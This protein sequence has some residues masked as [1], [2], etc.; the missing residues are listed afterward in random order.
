MSIVIGTYARRVAAGC[1]D[2]P[3]IDIV[4][5]G[6][7]HVAELPALD[8]HGELLPP[9]PSRQTALGF[10]WRAQRLRARGG[11]ETFAICDAGRLI[12]VAML[13]LDPASP[14]RAELGYWIA[15]AHRG[16]GYATAAARRVVSHAFDR[17]RLAVVSAR[18]STARSA[19]VVEKLSFR[20]VGFEPV[21]S[22]PAGD[23]VRRYEMARN[24]WSAQ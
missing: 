8:A 2:G 15:R 1:Q 11:H 10:V 5:L 4:P 7:G 24:E 3:T 23:V 19:R 18:C 6:V 9:L 14:D 12:G 22:N 21:A 20:F 16:Q 13:A 17:L